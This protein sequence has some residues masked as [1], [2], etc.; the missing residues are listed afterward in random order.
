MSSM[1]R[2]L[3]ASHATAAL[4]LIVFPAVDDIVLISD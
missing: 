1:E 4:Q 3:A 2:G